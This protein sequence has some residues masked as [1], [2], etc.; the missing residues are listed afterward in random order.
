MRKNR[1]IYQNPNPAKH[2]CEDDVIRAISLALNTDWDQVYSD[3][4]VLGASLHRMPNDKECYKAYLIRHGFHRTGI[5]HRKGSRRPTVLSFAEAHPHG[6]Y[7]LQAARHLVMIKD[8]R[9]FDTSDCG[10]KCLYGYWSI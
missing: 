7:I 9:I 6:I 5:S 3:L 8:G 1:F 4:C 2:E 10:D